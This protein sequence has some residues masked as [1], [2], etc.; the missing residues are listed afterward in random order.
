MGLDA[1]PLA[2][3]FAGKSK[4]MN[5]PNLI[6]LVRIFL[7]P[8]FIVAF[9]NPS[10]FR[11]LLAAGIFLAASLTDLLDG[12]LA[13]RWGQIT[14]LGKFLDPVADKVLVLAALVLLVD[15]QRVAAWIAILIIAR[16]IAVTGLRAVAAVSGVVIEAQESGKYKMVAQSIALTFLIVHSKYFMIDFHLWGTGFL[17]ISLTLTLYSGVLYFIRFWKRVGPG[18]LS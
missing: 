8:F 5:L 2:Y 16:E 9:Q 4:R 18:G 12:Y 14:K 7:I 6:T 13:R 1:S 10:D 11:S 15:F 17:W 3:P